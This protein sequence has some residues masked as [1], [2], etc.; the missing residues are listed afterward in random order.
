A[1]GTTAPQALPASAP[2]VRARIVN[3]PGYVNVKVQSMHQLQ[4][5]MR[6]IGS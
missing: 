3:R 2:R 4:R 1:P 5:R 6:R